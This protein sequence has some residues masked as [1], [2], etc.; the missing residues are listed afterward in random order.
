MPLAVPGW[1]SEGPSLVIESAARCSVSAFVAARCG[2]EVG[3]SYPI[4][5]GT[6]AKILFPCR[7]VERE[8]TGA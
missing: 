6:G 1:P 5:P 4:A 2:G 8:V 7:T 3:W